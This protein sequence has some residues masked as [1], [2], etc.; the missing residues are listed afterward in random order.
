[1]SRDLWERAVAAAE[2]GIVATIVGKPQVKATTIDLNQAAASYTLFTGTTQVVVVDSLVIKMPNH[3]AGGALTSISIQT[4]DAT[5]GIFITA[6]QGVV[7][8]LT[9]ENQL[10]WFGAMYITVGKLIQLT[11]AGGA[12]GA[13]HVCFVV[14]TY[15]SV[16]A[17]GLLA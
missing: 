9:A 15:H 1:M 10:I 7:A 13:A 14:C 11:I 5:P 3:A 4:N 2:A 6:A 16:V 12:E 8:S 17:G